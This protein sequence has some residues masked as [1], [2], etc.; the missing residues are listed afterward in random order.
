M[1]GEA[2]VRYDKPVLVLASTSTADGLDPRTRAES[3]LRQLP[4][5]VANATGLRVI[6]HYLWYGKGF[7][8]STL[9]PRLRATAFLGY[10]SLLAVV[11]PGHLSHGR[12]GR[13]PTRHRH[14]RSADA[15]YVTATAAYPR[16]YPPV[17][18]TE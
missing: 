4:V 1:A 8:G 11:L 16:S 13:E 9:T 18:S 6:S 17:T 15:A 14:M 12:I 10:E 7:G 5:L 3:D 2:R